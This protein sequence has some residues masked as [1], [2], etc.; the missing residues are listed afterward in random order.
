M[1]PDE[2]TIAIMGENVPARHEQ[3]EIDQLLFLPDNPRVYA[4]I[5]EMSDFTDLTTEEKQVRIYECMLRE[6][7]V[8]NL[9]PEIKRDGGLQE[10]III[11]HD[12]LQVIEGNSRLAAYK[13]LRD[14]TDEEKW[15][16]I[17]CLVVSSFTD[18]QQTRLLGQ[19]HLH[20]RTEWSPH[21]KAL[22]CFRW[23]IE[24][25]GDA[26]T[27]AKLS[28]FSTAEINKNVKI[29]Q[30]MK[31]NND[32]KLSRFS[33]Y[34]VLVRNKAISSAIDQRPALRDTLFSQ[35]RDGQFKAKEMRDH[36]PVVINKPR[37]LRKFEKGDVTLDD[38]FDR[39]KISGTEQRLKKVRDGLDDIEKGDINGLEHNELRAVEQVIRQIRQRLE[40]VSKMISARANATEG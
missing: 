21:A 35:I 10:P 36:L 32:N 27:L 31:D 29:I 30:L 14:D 26:A 28:G 4:A 19:T 37:I 8:K 13:K 3:R 18:D 2:T 39:A 11:R 20:G 24:K 38:A 9:I 12:T 34:D 6:P 5:R 23:I 17:R 7:S 1:K 25:K 22:F 33:Y 40:R 15:T 16:H